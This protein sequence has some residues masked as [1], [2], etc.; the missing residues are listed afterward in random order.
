MTQMMKAGGNA[1]DS[2]NRLKRFI[3]MMDSMTDAELD[4]LA[5]LSPSRVR[6]IAMGSGASVEE[7]NVLIMCQKKF[8]KMIGKMG[9]SGLMRGGDAGLAQQVRVG[10]CV[11]RR[12]SLDLT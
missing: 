8:G 7:V 4:G 11:R 3:N 2:G 5:P 12:C 9:K 10:C 1:E 6:R